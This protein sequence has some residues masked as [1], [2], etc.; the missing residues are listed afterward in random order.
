MFK[1][2]RAGKFRINKSNLN[3]EESI[4]RARYGGTA[5]GYPRISVELAP[6]TGKSIGEIIDD[7]SQNIMPSG[8]RFAYSWAMVAVQDRS[9]AM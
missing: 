6:M 1:G 2:D 8:M 3:G 4:C 9:T 7:R 5:R